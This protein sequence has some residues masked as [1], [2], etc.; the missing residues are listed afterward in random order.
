MTASQDLW[1]A[2]REQQTRELWATGMLA[3][4]IADRL[5]MNKKTVQG[6]LARMG[7]RRYR[8][9]KNPVGRG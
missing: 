7:L 2:E 4:E 1:T 6:K 9:F 5:G 3:R 8:N